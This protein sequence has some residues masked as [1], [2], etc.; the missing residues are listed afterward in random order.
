MGDDDEK[1]QKIE[2]ALNKELGGYEGDNSGA[3]DAVEY[4][5]KAYVRGDLVNGLLNSNI[6][7][8]KK[9][10]ARAKELEKREAAVSTK[11]KDRYLLEEDKAKLQQ[12]LEETTDELYELREKLRQYEN[13]TY[14]SGDF[15][16]KEKE[17]EMQKALAN[18]ADQA[19]YEEE[20]KQANEEIEQMAQRIVDLES[21]L[22]KL[23]GKTS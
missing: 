14:N 21:E 2:D 5:G 9:L 13:P 1:L 7:R 11:E 20:L 18:A 3:P 8:S 4:M 22:D 17:T 15:S 19:N 16:K 23:K 10:E 12:R 6:V